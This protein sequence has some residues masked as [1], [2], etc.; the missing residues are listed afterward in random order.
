VS[1]T[2]D[3]FNSYCGDLITGA[4]TPEEKQRAEQAADYLISIYKQFPHDKIVK[5]I[6]ATNTGNW[7]PD[8]RPAKRLENATAS[9]LKP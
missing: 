1:G 6:I 2:Q 5:T 9:S 4:A 3:E 7:S 8:C